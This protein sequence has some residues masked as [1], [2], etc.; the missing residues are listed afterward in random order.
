MRGLLSLNTVGKMESVDKA[1]LKRH[2]VYSGK[3]VKPQ[4]ILDV[5]K[6]NEGMALA[7]AQAYL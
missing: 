2:L 3:S 7:F 5:L 1:V 4:A 6:G